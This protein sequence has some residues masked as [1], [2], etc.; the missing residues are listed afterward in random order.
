MSS[1]PRKTRQNFTAHGFIDGSRPFEGSAFSFLPE[2]FHDAPLNNRGLYLLN[3]TRLCEQLEELLKLKPV[4]VNSLQE[5]G[6]HEPMDL[7]RPRV[8]DVRPYLPEL[9]A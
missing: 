3:I 9:L 1:G 4:D 8:E 5:S 6:R 2:G 7:E